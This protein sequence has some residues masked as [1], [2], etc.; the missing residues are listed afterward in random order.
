MIPLLF[1]PLRLA[2]AAAGLVTNL[3]SNLLGALFM[4]GAVGIIAVVVVA[5]YSST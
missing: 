4:L 1:A 5:W 2:L 3:I